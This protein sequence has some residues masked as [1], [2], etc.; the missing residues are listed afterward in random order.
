MFLLG[1]KNFELPSGLCPSWVIRIW[2]VMRILG[3]PEYPCIEKLGSLAVSQQELFNSNMSEQVSQ[4]LVTLSVC[5]QPGFL[6]F[7]K[8]QRAFSCGATGKESALGSCN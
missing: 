4:L 6:A 3:G 7:L 2:H 8:Q 5:Y 1:S